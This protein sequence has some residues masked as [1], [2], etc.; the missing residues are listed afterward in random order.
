[1][2]QTPLTTIQDTNISVT[3]MYLLK[4]AL[5]TGAD[6]EKLQQLLDLQKEYEANEARKAYSVAFAE[7]K[8]N[9]PLIDKDVTVNYQNKNGDVTNYK[10]SS[11]QN[12]VEKIGSELSKHGLSHSWTMDQN[13]NGQVV[14][15]C[16][17]TH[18]L[19]HCEENTLKSSPDSSGGKNNIQAIGSA[20]T[21]LQRYTLLGVT[22]LATK[23]QDD[24]GA[25][26][27]KPEDTALLTVDHK[28]SIQKLLK[29]TKSDL[30]QFLIYMNS[31]S[32]DEVKDSQ[33]NA[34]MVALATKQAKINEQ[35]QPK[36]G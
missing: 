22:G 32:L 1:M 16:K 26:S 8:K 25:Q 14:V 17:L 28:A 2:T 6:I 5:D 24:D 21:Y 29:S 13:E 15:T 10:H 33:Y 23:G 18:I 31:K 19:G 27:E 35:A 34:A 12:V 4:M 9:P 3:P 36:A 20:V 7:F 30:T 11:L